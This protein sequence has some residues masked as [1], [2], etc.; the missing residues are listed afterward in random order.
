MNTIARVTNIA[1]AFILLTTL[2]ATI[3]ALVRPDIDVSMI[4]AARWLVVLVG[5]G[6]AFTLSW[7][8][9]RR[10]NIL[11]GNKIDALRGAAFELVTMMEQTRPGGPES[12][13][14]VA[15]QTLERFAIV[16][17]ER[18]VRTRPLVVREEQDLGL[19][20]AGLQ[21]IETWR[22]EARGFR[23]D[24]AATRRGV[25][26]FLALIIDRNLQV[27]YTLMV[28]HMKMQRDDMTMTMPDFP[29]LKMFLDLPTD[30]PEGDMPEMMS[31]Q[32][33]IEFLSSNSALNRRGADIFDGLE[34]QTPALN[35]R[36]SIVIRDGDILKAMR[37]FIRND[38][39]GAAFP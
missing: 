13:A 35:G 31:G 29:N 3:I 14:A 17:T 10:W 38:D 37:E 18:A 23:R 7:W 25:A 20:D 36:P 12:R 15:E 19:T 26:A 16:G 8:L 33:L 34:Y 32:S 2:I 21:L 6:A 4:L 24:R 30:W 27:G 9:S 28:K 22:N 39:T 1:F 5:V 11:V